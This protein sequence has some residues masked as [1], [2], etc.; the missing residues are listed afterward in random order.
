MLRLLKSTP[1]RAQRSPGSRTV[2][3]LVLLLPVLLVPSEALFQRSPAWGYSVFC[4]ALVA[5]VL[6]FAFVSPAWGAPT[7]V[8]QNT[9]SQTNS[10]SL[11]VTLTNPTTVGNLL[12]MVGAN[13]SGPLTS[14][15]GGG[16]ATWSQATGSYIN[17]NCE[18]WYGVVTTSS[19]T[20]VTRH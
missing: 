3:W 15:S 17:A 14:V 8:Q 12:I 13:D 11:T 7:I 1:S 4:R 16:A 9:G 18:I 2:F 10:S 20:G 6:V 19:S 5:L